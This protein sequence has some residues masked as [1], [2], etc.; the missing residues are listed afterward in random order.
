MFMSDLVVVVLAV[1]ASVTV[2]VIVVAPTVV[3]EEVVD[4]SED[5]V[6]VA[7]LCTQ[8][9]NAVPLKQLACSIFA[10]SQQSEGS[11]PCTTTTPT[12]IGSSMHACKQDSKGTLPNKSTSGKASPPWPS[13][14]FKPASFSKWSA[15]EPVSITVVVV[16]V[17]SVVRVV[18]VVGGSV[19]VVVG[20]GVVEA[21]VVVVVIVDTC[22]EPTLH[23]CDLAKRQFATR[24][25]AP[26][27]VVSSRHAPDLASSCPVTLS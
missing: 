11:C 3:E 24:T 27:W 18:V 9:S 6:D 12:H 14:Q 1:E 7:S 19:V 8:V 16:A 15:S 20:A 23:C 26:A 21:V 2:V 13:W 10:R 22:H 25:S 17:S 4:V 5:E